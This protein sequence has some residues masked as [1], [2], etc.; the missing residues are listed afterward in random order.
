M[1]EQGI[2]HLECLRSGLSGAWSI[3]PVE[4]ALATGATRLNAR[5]ARIGGE[6]LQPGS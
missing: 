4:G 1:L 6:R 2:G 5:P 3:V